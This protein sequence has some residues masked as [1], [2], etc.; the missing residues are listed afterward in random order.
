VLHPHLHHH[1]F[2]QNQN[3]NPLFH[4]RKINNLRLKER[5]DKVEEKLQE[6]DCELIQLK[7]FVD[8]LEV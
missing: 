5:I 3:P 7:S 4:K 1:H 2:K 6:I 8:G